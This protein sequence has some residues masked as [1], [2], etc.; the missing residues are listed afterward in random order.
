[1][2]LSAVSQVNGQ[3]NV[4]LV[5][6]LTTSAPATRDF[7][8][9]K[10]LL[11]LVFSYY[12]PMTTEVIRYKTIFSKTV[13]SPDFPQKSSSNVSVEFVFAK[14]AEDVQMLQDL[15]RTYGLEKMVDENL[16]AF[17]LRNF[18][19]VNNDEQVFNLSSLQTTIAA[20]VSRSMFVQRLTFSDPGI[21]E[22]CAKIYLVLARLKLITSEKVEGVQEKLKLEGSPPQPLTRE[23][24]L[25]CVNEGVVQAIPQPDD[26]VIT[27]LSEKDVLCETHGKYLKRAPARRHHEED[28]SNETS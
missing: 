12:G 7:V 9:P 14:I 3:S 23:A 5:P 26:Q 20:I 6:S 8:L 10:D 15:G 2:S 11:G 22:N 17:A 27:A 18:Q 28:S 19:V 25:A 24:L 1:M 4:S 16:R 13:V 21:D